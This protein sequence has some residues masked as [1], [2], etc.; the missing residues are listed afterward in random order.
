MYC[1]C[2]IFPAFSQHLSILCAIIQ[3]QP[4]QLHNL[5]LLFHRHF[6]YHWAGINLSFEYI[7]A[8]ARQAVQVHTAPFSNCKYT[9]TG[10]TVF[11]L[12]PFR[13]W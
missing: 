5:V 4:S 10:D 1:I 8:N 9:C 2:H 13:L 12:S 3:K 6:Y 7:H 11:A